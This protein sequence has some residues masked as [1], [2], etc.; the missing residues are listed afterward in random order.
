MKKGD[1][2]KRGIKEREKIN[3]SLSIILVAKAA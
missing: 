2:E 1:K 3:F